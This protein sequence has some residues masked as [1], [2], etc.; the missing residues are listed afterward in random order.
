MSKVRH[1]IQRKSGGRA[2]LVSGNPPVVKEAE[3]G[4]SGDV[5]WKKGGRVKKKRAAGGKVEIGKMTGGA[6]QQ[7]ADKPARKRGGA[8]NRAS[9]GGANRSPFSSARGTTSTSG[10]SNPTDTYGGTP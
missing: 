6:V 2:A 10:S 4:Q 1:E 9:G 8:V 7:R 3:E 5:D